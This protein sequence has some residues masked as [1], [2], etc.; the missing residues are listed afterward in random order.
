MVERVLPK[1][2]E[3]EAVVEKRQ[4]QFL[5]S[6]PPGVTITGPNLF[7]LQ[8]VCGFACGFVPSWSGSRG[9]E[10]EGFCTFVCIA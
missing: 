8:R 2:L 5:T 9:S 3:S 4:A 7:K 10:K 1:R 6:A